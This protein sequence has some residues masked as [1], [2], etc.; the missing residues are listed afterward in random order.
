MI[1]VFLKEKLNHLTCLVKGFFFNFEL[2]LKVFV[3]TKE[4]SN[5]EI[6]FIKAVQWI[7]IVRNM[8]TLK[9]IVFFTTILL[10]LGNIT[11]YFALKSEISI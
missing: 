5:R 8:G 7:I 9:K 10:G 2:K 4:V 6:C 1:L 3:M 11:N